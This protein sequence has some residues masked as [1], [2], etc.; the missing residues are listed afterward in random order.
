[1]RY[2][3]AV[4]QSRIPLRRTLRIG[5]RRNPEFA[6]FDPPCR[7]AEPFI[8]QCGI[9]SRHDRIRFVRHVHIM[10]TVFLHFPPENFRPDHEKPFR[11]RMTR[12]QERNRIQSGG[13]HLF[14]PYPDSEFVQMFNIIIHTPRGIVRQE[15]IT[16]P[17]GFQAAQKGQR[18]RE[19]F[20]PSVNCAVHIHHDMAES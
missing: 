20:F 15:R 19:Q 4:N 9:K 14:P 6:P 12:F 16:D 8:T 3:S 17:E 13:E 11:R 10:K 1:M 7:L 18:R 5:M 2:A